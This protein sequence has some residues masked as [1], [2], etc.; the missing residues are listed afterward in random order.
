MDTLVKVRKRTDLYGL[1]QAD[2]DQLVYCISDNTIYHLRDKSRIAHSDG[3]EQTAA[4]SKTVNLSS[5]ITV[6]S[7]DYLTQNTA[8]LRYARL[9]VD[10]I[11]Q[12]NLT[13]MEDIV[14]QGNIIAYGTGGPSTSWWDNMPWATAVSVGGIKIGTGLVITDGILSTESGGGFDED[15]D[16]SPT[17]A[18]T[19]TQTPLVGAVAVSL[20]GHN[21]SGLYDA[22]NT[23]SDLMSTHNSTY[24]HSNIHAPGSDNQDLS[25]YATI[26]SLGAY[27]MITNTMR[28][29]VYTDLTAVQTSGMQNYFG[30]TN[31]GLPSGVN[32]AGFL[33]FGTNADNYG[34]QIAVRY[35]SPEFWYR[36][37][38]AGATQGWKKLAHTDSPTFT[39]I[40]NIKGSSIDAQIYPAAY[41]IGITSTGAAGGGWSRGYRFQ[42]KDTGVGLGGFGAM[43]NENSLSYLWIGREYNDQSAVFYVDGAVELNYDGSKKLET[44]SNGVKTYGNHFIKGVGNPLYF[45]TT[46]AENA[47]W[48]QVVDN[49]NLSLVC[50][51]GT[52]SKIIL[53]NGGQV[54]LYYG[55]VKKFE[56]QSGGTLTTG[57]IKATGNI[58]AYAS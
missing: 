27:A 40:V 7:G 33:S 41:G 37:V 3:W 6:V 45:D 9:A 11:L 34:A 1:R 39:G 48:I 52:S 43:G 56:T 24:N 14:S 47:A 15:G 30:W 54:E 23:A 51:R 16:Y 53:S 8:D 26:A 13:V 29:G 22:L 19:F 57:D 4:V 35:D 32:Y 50:N 20:F 38:A 5:N 12:G 17:G 49:Y 42:R 25:G 18:W 10:N 2:T 31:T 46:G 28:Y 58:I 36:Q 21:H 55:S 44:A